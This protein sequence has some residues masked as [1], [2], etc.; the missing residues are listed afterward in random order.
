MTPRRERRVASGG[1]P[2]AISSAIVEGRFP[3]AR[4]VRGGRDT[5]AAAESATREMIG[6]DQA[7]AKGET[8]NAV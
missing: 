4:T 2:T 3:K 8:S 7:Y 5:L 1:A 6:N